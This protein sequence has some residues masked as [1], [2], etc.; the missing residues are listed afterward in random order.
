MCMRHR[1]RSADFHFFGP[2]TRVRLVVTPSR[3]ATMAPSGMVSSMPMNTPYL[4]FGTKSPPSRTACSLAGTITQSPGTGSFDGTVLAK[5]LCLRRKQAWGKT[6]AHM[7]TGSFSLL[8]KSYGFLLYN[9]NV[10]FST[11]ILRFVPWLRRCLKN[12]NFLHG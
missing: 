6:C 4:T 3:T 9:P 2:D 7:V 11:S 8:Q 1:F 10:P 12:T 5:A